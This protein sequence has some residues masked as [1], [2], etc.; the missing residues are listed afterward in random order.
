MLVASGSRSEYELSL[1]G[2][3]DVFTV[4]TNVEIQLRARELVTPPPRP[5]LGRPLPAVSDFC[6]QI[7][8]KKQTNKQKK[9]LLEP[10]KD[11][12]FMNPH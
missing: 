11:G 10:V 12:T 5:C 1:L 6:I 3:R 4:C 9:A 8:K 2:R 7:Q